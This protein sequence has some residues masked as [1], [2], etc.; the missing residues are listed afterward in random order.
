M[1]EYF[2]QFVNEGTGTVSVDDVE[3]LLVSVGRND[4][5][6]IIL[7]REGDDFSSRS[8]IDVTN[9][10]QLAIDALG[11]VDGHSTDSLVDAL[12]NYQISFSSSLGSTIDLPAEAA[13]FGVDSVA[14]AVQP[15]VIPIGDFND[16]GFA[17]FIAAVNEDLAA[18]SDVRTEAR[19][20]LGN[21]LGG[22]VLLD[23]TTVTLILPATVLAPF[24]SP[25][26]PKAEFATGDFNADGIDDLA[27]SVSD[28]D[29]PTY[30]SAGV[31]IV[32]GSSPP[33]PATIDLV[34]DHDVAIV[35]AQGELTLKC[36]AQHLSVYV[37][38]AGMLR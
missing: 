7:T 12:G 36:C 35:G 14:L 27:V 23:A 25:N 37:A 15:V 4:Q 26:L 11:L 21:G 19:I 31:Y 13:S 10:N 18:A 28:A 38:V 24:T 34:I 22:D 33:L 30:A 8:S 17:D 6:R 29:D 5:G 1:G 9:P 3:G 16:D 2:L 20:V 32:F